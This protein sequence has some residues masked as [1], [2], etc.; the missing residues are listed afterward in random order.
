LATI[1]R[2]GP[3]RN[4]QTV[5]RNTSNQKFIKEIKELLLSQTYQQNVPVFYGNMNS[6]KSSGYNEYI[7]K[8]VGVFSSRKRIFIINP[9]AELVYRFCM[10]CIINNIRKTIIEKLNNLLHLCTFKTQIFILR[11][12]GLKDSSL[13]YYK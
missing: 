1:F 10:F 3:T 4:N 7:C 6:N 11:K 12:N 8:I 5:A 13:I 9:F 2:F